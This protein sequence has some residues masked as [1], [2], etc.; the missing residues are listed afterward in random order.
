[1]KPATARLQIVEKPPR[2]K[3][4]RQSKLRREWEAYLRWN[5]YAVGFVAPASM[6]PQ[7][8]L[9]WQGHIVGIA[10]ISWILLSLKSTLF[11]CWGVERR[12]WV[13]AFKEGLQAIANLSVLAGFIYH[14]YLK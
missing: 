6:I 7:V 9:V 13:V 11:A 14:A 5:A 10:L 8:A 4:S 2:A 3:R 12:V 1:M